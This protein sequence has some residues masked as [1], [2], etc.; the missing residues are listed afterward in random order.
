MPSLVPSLTLVEEGRFPET[1]EGWPVYRTARHSI[2]LVFRRRGE[3]AH[4]MIES[5]RRR[6]AEKQR[7]YQRAVYKQA[8]PPG[9]PPEPDKAWSHS[10]RGLGVQPNELWVKMRCPSLS[11]LTRNFLC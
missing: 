11:S 7:I 5:H 9:F 4:G 6:A 3:V 10:A 2:R 8:T 1:P